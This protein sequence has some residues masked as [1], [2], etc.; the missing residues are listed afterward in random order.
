MDR[1]GGRGSEELGRRQGGKG[2]GRGG[3]EVWMLGGGETCIFNL[4]LR[5]KHLSERETGKK[6]GGG[7]GVIS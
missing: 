3:G 7:G 4:S 1:R 2:G 5:G 6:V